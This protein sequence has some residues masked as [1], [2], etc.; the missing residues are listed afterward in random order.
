MAIQIKEPELITFIHNKRTGGTSVTNWLEKNFNGKR[1]V[2]KHINFQK[3]SRIGDLG[4]TFSTVRNPWDKCVST[5][6]YQLRKINERTSKID[7]GQGRKHSVEEL[8]RMKRNW[9]ITFSDWL[10]KYHNGYF[11][12]PQHH[13]VSGVDYI[14]KFETLEEDFEYI[15]KRLDCFIPLPKKNTTQHKI[16]RDYYTDKSKQIV[17]E[18]FAKDIEVL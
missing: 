11:S 5:F 10:I 2:G 17:A 13:V 12:K 6:H 15:Q 14:M 3:T 16:Y 7:N 8:E 1:I 9:N 18:I 4:F